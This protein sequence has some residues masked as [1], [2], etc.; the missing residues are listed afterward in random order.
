MTSQNQSRVLITTIFTSQAGDYGSLAGVDVYD[1]WVDT[2]V[3]GRGSRCSV[4]FLLEFTGRVD[5]SKIITA[6]SRLHQRI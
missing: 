6:E 1:P 2:C 5:G 4:F 3:G